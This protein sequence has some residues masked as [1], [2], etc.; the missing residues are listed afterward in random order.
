MDAWDG[1]AAAHVSD[2]LVRDLEL[3]AQRLDE[4]RASADPYVW[5]TLRE[6]LRRITRELV[7]ADR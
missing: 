5:R 2:R 7:T 3:F 1:E 4:A 6:D